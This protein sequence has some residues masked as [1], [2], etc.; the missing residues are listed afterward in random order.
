MHD[1]VRQRP[2]TR[3][4]I[5][6]GRHAVRAWRRLDRGVRNDVRSRARQGLGHPD[7]AVAGIAVGRARNTLGRGFAVRYAF[8]VLLVLI[9]VLGAAALVNRL[10]STPPGQYVILVIIA[11]VGGIVTHATARREAEQVEEAN[12]NTLRADQTD[13]G[14]LG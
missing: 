8:R 11:L 3:A 13:H 14:S 7:P 4:E 12:L 9:G 10:T 6:M 2:V 5:P 1:W